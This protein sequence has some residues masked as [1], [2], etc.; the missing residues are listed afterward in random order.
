[1]HEF[2]HEVSMTAPCLASSAYHPFESPEEFILR[3]TD[4]IWAARG[5]GR[6]RQYYAPTLSVHTPYGSKRV[7]VES[8]MEMTLR[9]ISSYPQL[10]ASGIGEDVICE[11]RSANSFISS[12]RIYNSTAQLGFSVYGPPN[13][14]TWSARAM[15]H[16]LVEDGRIVEEWLL[17][18]EGGVVED[19]GLNP[20]TVAES[21]VADSEAAVFTQPVPTPLHAGVSGT[22]PDTDPASE[23]V[24]ALFEDVWNGRN[25]DLVSRYVSSQVCCETVKGRRAHRYDGYQI[26]IINLLAAFPDATLK[27]IDIAVNTSPTAGTRVAAVWVLTGTYSGNPVYGPVTNSPVRIMG[28]SHFEV[29]NGRVHREW[30]GYDEIA[31]RAQIIQARRAA[32]VD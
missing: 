12:H 24:L 11:T 31:V 5:I 25:F 17:R 27:V 1:M 19:L 15:A 2:K 28:I 23:M 7:A 10:G 9:R 18:D 30:R 32:A 6:I 3:C 8:V 20:D 29:V 4:E 22:R 26:E 16:C 14:K 13:G 21:L